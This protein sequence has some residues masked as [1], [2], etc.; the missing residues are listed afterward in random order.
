MFFNA[1][2]IFVFQEKQDCTL[3]AALISQHHQVQR[4]KV[5]TEQPQILCR[6]SN[7]AFTT[8]VSEHVAAEVETTN[9]GLRAAL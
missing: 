1:I 5:K 8:Q 2:T 7:Y 9:S 6:L 4:T 3:I